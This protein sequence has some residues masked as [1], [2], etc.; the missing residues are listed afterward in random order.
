MADQ[1]LRKQLQLGE[2]LKYPGELVRGLRIPILR[3]TDNLEA[4]ECEDKCLEDSRDSILQAAIHHL[5]KQDD[6][7]V[8]N[9]AVHCS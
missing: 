1:K 7:S 5:I 6:Q 9:V 3:N 2:P 4:E 8:P